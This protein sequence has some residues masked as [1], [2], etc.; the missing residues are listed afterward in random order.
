MEEGGRN[1]E[2]RTRRGGDDSTPGKAGRSAKVQK[3]TTR[4]S[5]QF[6]RRG[7]GQERGKRRT[8]GKS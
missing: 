1:S 4:L 5:R 8:E 6:S 2:G 7:E 3:K